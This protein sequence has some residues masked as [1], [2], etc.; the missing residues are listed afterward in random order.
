MT[1]KV[2]VNWKP[3]PH[4]GKAFHQAGAKLKS[5]WEAL[6]PGDREPYPDE[7]GLERLVETHRA[8]KPEGTLKAAAKTLQEAW[9]AYHEGDF[10][11]AVETGLSVG[12]L[13]Y[14]VANKAVNIY[15]TYLE[16]DHDRRNAELL[17]VV[18][19]AE[20]L[21]QNAPSL[22]NA[23]FLHAQALGRYSQSQ[24]IAKA[25]AE[26]TG[27]KV[28]HSLDEAL[29][30]EPKHAD[31]HV[32]LGLYHALIV[33][34]L[35]AMIGSLTYGASKEEALAHFDKALKLNPGSAIARVE[36]ANALVMIYGKSKLAE[37]TGLYEKAAACEPADAM[38]YLDVELAKQELAD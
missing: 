33:H 38:Q 30:L 7:A 25:L 15:A 21:Q 9:R 1:T 37:A 31:A 19:R 12:R 36:Y 6:H 11:K 34:K 17:Q 22:P 24:S 4:D 26:G 29:R 3:F 14:N 2:S 10:G 27:A 18:R 16:T 20:D 5:H 28:R 35:G 23:W 8:L 32:A 13:G